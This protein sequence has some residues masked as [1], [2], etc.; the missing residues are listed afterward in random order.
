MKIIQ[1]EEEQLECVKSITIDTITEIYPHYYPKGAVDFF[2]SHHNED[3]IAKDIRS[4][5]V[6]LGFDKEQHAVGTVTIR[7]NE[8]CRLFVRPSFHKR[9]FGRELLDFAENRIAQQHGTAMLAASLP[10]KAIY[11]K[12]GY[13]ET[14]TH[15]I[16]TECGDFLC[17]DVMC[18]NLSSP[19]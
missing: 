2:L 14:K 3:N 10:A 11:L 16:Q 8:I 12:R 19:V 4:G 17:Y 1:V 9:G 6:F 5:I 18:K 13:A 7:E 15:S